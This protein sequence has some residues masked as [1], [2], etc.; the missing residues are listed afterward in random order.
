MLVIVERVATNRIE[1]VPLNN[2]ARGLETTVG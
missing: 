2:S 1:L